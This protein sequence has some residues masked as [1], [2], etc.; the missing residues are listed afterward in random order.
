[1][2]YSQPINSQ[3]WYGRFVESLERAYT[4]NEQD[5]ADSFCLFYELF[6]KDNPTFV[7]EQPEWAAKYEKLYRKAQWV[8]LPLLIDENDV[9]DL[10]QNHVLVL[11][12][13]PGYD[14]DERLRERL[15]SI[16]IVERDKLKNK[17]KNAL[18]QNKEKLSDNFTN[19]VTHLLEKGSVAGWTSEFQSFMGKDFKDALLLARFYTESKPYN[20]QKAEAKVLL[21]S[22]FMTVARLNTSSQTAA[23]FEEDKIVSIEGQLMSY[24]EGGDVEPFDDE[25]V[26]LVKR[27]HPPETE[28]SRRK[29]IREK[30]ADPPD[31]A[32][33]VEPLVEELLKTSKGEPATLQ[34]ALVKA[35]VSPSGAGKPNATQVIAAVRAVATSGNLFE[36]LSDK[37]LQELLKNSYEKNRRT[38]DA[39]SLKVFPN[40]PEHVKGFLR[41]VLEEILRMDENEAA[42]QMLQIANLLRKRGDNRLMSAAFYDESAG[43]FLWGGEK[44]EKPR[45]G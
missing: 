4:Y 5:E 22:L 9:V 11:L 24:R 20:T 12:E 38:Q 26:E 25:L 45:A 31:V 2:P 41:M 21:K 35:I 6:K 32:K 30:F 23:G 37:K 10:F 8:A 43:R 42:R 39:E 40:A 1:M 17:I 29:K 33:A 7:K 13:L 36:V 15:I 27:L 18:L 34:G 28:E 14:L 3:E 44:M 16:N 19:T